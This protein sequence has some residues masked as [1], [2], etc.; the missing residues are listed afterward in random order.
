MSLI[1]TSGDGVIFSESF[2]SLALVA[3][4]GGVPTGSPVIKNG[5]TLNGTTQDVTFSKSIKNIKSIVIKIN[6]TALDQY[7][8]GFADGV[9]VELT[10]GGALYGNGIT[11]PTYYV[12]GVATSSISTGEKMLVVT[13]NTAISTTS[14]TVGKVLDGGDTGYGAGIIKDIR[15][16]PSVLSAEDAKDLYEQDTVSELDRPIIN[17]PFRSWYYN[18]SG[19]A[20][21]DNIGSLKGTATL[22]DGTTTTTFPTQLS[23]K[24][25]S[26]DGDDYFTKAVSLNGTYT[27]AIMGK[28]TTPLNNIIA[29]FRTDGG[30]G[31]FWFDG[32]GLLAGSSGTPYVNGVQTG[33]VGKGIQTFFVAGITLTAT[34]MKLLASYTL[35]T[36][37]AGSF[38]EFQ[39][40]PGT[41]TAQQIKILHAKYLKNINV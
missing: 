10:S 26:N 25:V 20:V 39:I 6:I 37:L 22:G 15:L 23:P 2:I 19:I 13:T 12:N 40:F 1:A 36:K 4:N 21:T 38:Y 41:L 16:Y 35:G 32:S 29:D 14:L 7:I 18:G 31:Y 30:T 33:T 8:F 27:I 5:V 3:A 28:I 24:G 34:E 17:F 11:S 9:Y